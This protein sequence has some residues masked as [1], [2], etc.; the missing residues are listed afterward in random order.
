MITKFTKKGSKIEFS[1]ALSLSLIDINS[2]F[3]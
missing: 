1:K 2:I 3:L